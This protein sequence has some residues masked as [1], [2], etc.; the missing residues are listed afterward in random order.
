[1]TGNTPGCPFNARGNSVKEKESQLTKTESQEP[2]ISPH[3][4]IFFFVGSLWSERESFPNSFFGGLGF[5]I[6]QRKRIFLG[7]IR[8]QEL[9]ESVFFGRARFSDSGTC[10]NRPKAAAAE[11]GSGTDSAFPGRRRGSLTAIEYACFYLV[12]LTSACLY[13][14]SL[15][16]VS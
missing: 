16:V 2:M 10:P 15:E 5:I 8:I 11:S 9:L 1:M 6:P 7:H 13:S 12:N 14:P 4:I 3:I